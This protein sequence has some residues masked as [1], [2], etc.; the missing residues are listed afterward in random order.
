MVRDFVAC[1]FIADPPQRGCI[2]FSPTR[3]RYCTSADCELRPSLFLL[4]HSCLP[5]RYLFLHSCLPT[6]YLFLY[7]LLSRSTSSCDVALTS[8]LAGSSAWSRKVGSRQGS[9]IC[10]LGL[11]VTRHSYHHLLR[12]HPRV[13][14]QGQGKRSQVSSSL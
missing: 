7:L 13:S 1:C 9:S 4:P 11:K 8:S 3:D 2:A 6:R 5:T 10:S 14:S 12:R